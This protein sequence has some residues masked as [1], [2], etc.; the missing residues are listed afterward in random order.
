MRIG[1]NVDRQCR[2]SFATRGEMPR[3]NAGARLAVQIVAN[4]AD[5]EVRFVRRRSQAR[6]DRVQTRL[7]RAQSTHEG[8]SVKTLYRKPAD[9]I[10][11]VIVVHER[12]TRFGSLGTAQLLQFGRAA[13]L[14]PMIDEARRRGRDL[15]GRRQGFAQPH[16]L[17]P[18]R[19][20]CIDRQREMFEK[21]IDQRRIVAR[22]D[23]ERI[24]GLVGEAGAFERQFDVA[25]L[26]ART[27]AGEHQILDDGGRKRILLVV[28]GLRHR[29]GCRSTLGGNTR[30]MADRGRLGPGRGELGHDSRDPFGRGVF[31]IDVA[32]HARFQPRRTEFFQTTVDPLAALAIALVGGVTQRQHG[33]PKVR[34]FRGLA[35]LQ[36]FKERHGGL[37]R[38]ALAVRAGDHQQVL[39]F[40]ELAR[41]VI[42]H[43]GDDG[44]N[45][46]LL[47]GFRQ[48]LGESL[49]VARFG[50]VED[51]QRSRRRGCNRRRIGV[52]AREQCEIVKSA[53]RARVVIEAGKVSA[54]PQCLTRLERHRKRVDALPL[55]V[56]QAGPRKFQ[57]R[58]R[59]ASSRRGPRSPIAS[60]RFG[61]PNRW[62][63]DPPIRIASLGAS[64]KR[65]ILPP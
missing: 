18:C 59:I 13:E 16:R 12:R 41:L 46:L 22:H 49:A 60:R 5:R 17:L 6:R 64:R 14:G 19:H 39:L 29:R 62:T 28:D 26:L 38:I 43:V 4:R 7:E 23:A 24:A 31:I 51:R 58:H 33:K 35:A 61:G 65:M 37:R 9:D 45:P 27:A 36:E 30:S 56:A 42:R 32:I 34:K 10:D 55:L 54:Q 47:R 3:S 48:R 21:T 53:K 20:G 11:Y 50:P 40:L 44:R 8:F 52:A 25:R 63:H 57:F 2:V 1:L 15:E